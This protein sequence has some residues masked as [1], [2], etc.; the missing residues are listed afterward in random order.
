[1]HLIGVERIIL[2]HFQLDLYGLR[3]VDEVFFAVLAQHSIFLGAEDL[4]Q[5]RLIVEELFAK[6]AEVFDIVEAFYA[7]IVRI[8][9]LH[10]KLKREVGG[11][12]KRL[13]WMFEIPQTVHRFSHFWH[14]QRQF[15]ERLSLKTF[16]HH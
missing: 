8:D 13:C 1:M 15:E 10:P 12:D 16:E 4:I 5:N 9:G 2:R 11:N 3:D 14:F 7:D 6:L